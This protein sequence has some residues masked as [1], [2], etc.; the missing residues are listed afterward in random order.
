K[1][2]GIPGDARALLDGARSAS[3]IF[4]G[5][6]THLFLLD[7]GVGLTLYTS[8]Y[9]PSLGDWGFQ[10]HPEQGHDFSMRMDDPVNVIITHG[11]P[12]GILDYGDSSERTGCPHLFVTVAHVRPQMHCFGHIHEA[13]GAELVTWRKMASE[14]PSYFTDIDNGKSS[15]GA[16]LSTLDNDDNR[17]CYTT[18]H[19]SGDP[20]EIQLVTQ[21]LFVNAAIEG[22]EDRPIQLLCLV[23]LELPMTS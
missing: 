18:S 19:C 8:S 14:K 13:L 5:E 22:S 15:V 3:I 2:Y 7:N 23:D 6:G 12:K 17:L 21:T 16:K 1:E 10:Y 11:P 9:T 4:L 20:L